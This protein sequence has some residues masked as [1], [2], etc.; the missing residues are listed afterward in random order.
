MDKSRKKIA[1]D[2]SRNAIADSKSSSSFFL[3]H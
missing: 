2:Y 1:Q 3:E